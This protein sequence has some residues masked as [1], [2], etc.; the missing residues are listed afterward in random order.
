MNYHIIESDHNGH[1][2][3][4]DRKSNLGKAKHRK[5]EL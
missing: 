3:K 1:T 5:S 2:V 4:L